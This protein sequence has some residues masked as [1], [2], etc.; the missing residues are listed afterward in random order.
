VK[1]VIDVEANSLNNP[2]QIWVIVCKDIATD[3][4]SI[5]RNVTTDAEAARRFLKF[6]EGVETWIGHNFLG[7]DYPALRDLLGF[8]YTDAID[9]LVISKL[10]DYSRESGHSIEAYGQEFGL[11]KGKFSDWSKWSQE[12]EDYC[13]RDVDICAKIY[14][15]YKH[16]ISDPAWLPAI[17]LEHSFQLV[18]NGLHTNGFA[19][20]SARA[21]TLLRTVEEQL[22]ELDKDILNAFPPKE[23]L[24]RE[25]TPTFT[26]FG[27]ISRTS[28]PR[29]LHPQIH[30]YV[31][32]ETYK[33]TRL[34]DFNPA[35]HKQV[36]NVLNE[37]GWSPVEKT[38]THI[39]TER[40]INR[41]KYLR[42][43]RLVVDLDS[44]YA[45][46]KILEKFGWKINEANLSTLPD[47]APVPAR[48]LAKRILLESRRRTLT[49]W[50]GL[51]AD[52]GRIHGKF[53]GIGAWTHRMAHQQPNTANIPNEFDTNGNKKLLGKELRSL[54]RAPPKRLL[55]GVDA[56]GIQLRVFAHYIDDKEFTEA[57]VNGK[58]SD[59]TD[60]HS[61][62]QRIM[63]DTC[64][65]RQAAKRFIFA[66]LLGA[67]LGKLAEI[68]ECNRGQAEEALSRLTKR[69]SGFDYLKRE[70]IPHDA[71]R[72]WFKGLDGRRVGIP[73]D[74]PGERKHLCMSGYLQNGEAIIMKRAT[75][76]WEDKLHELK[77]LLVNLVHDEW[78][79]EC[80]NN[81]EL[82]LRIADIQAQSLTL[83]G[84]ELG[85]KCPLA[86]SYWNEDHK[87]Y[88]IGT[89][90][91]QT[92]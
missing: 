60:P 68:L 19:F 70:V 2:T 86:G 73:G 27:T 7:Y 53:Y 74:T 88:T 17:N 78:Q 58:K 31:A 4:V 9:T 83:V 81:V 37:A 47:T 21:T 82:A 85:L 54:W 42:K 49:E 18:V 61:L 40:E 59:K 38:K 92:H 28:V 55:V 57:L 20:N 91:Y 39:E 50:L 76:K 65:T 66:L 3:D 89:N 26:K 90:W 84:Q 63:G 22:A 48:L 79:T 69:Y 71:K 15:H 11:E 62:N 10:V 43:D 72:G 29:S 77:A 56:E 35:S 16:I 75:L 67:G 32:G 80:P 14:S 24:I 12:M 45:K 36:I 6:A 5:F 33:H 87:D 23:V 44:L 46:M 1:V 13:V 25:F 34:V 51:V 8:T 30:L 64:K 41:A 52:D